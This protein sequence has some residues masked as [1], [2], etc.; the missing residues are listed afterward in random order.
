[1]SVKVTKVACQS[2]GANLSLDESIRFVTCG[3]C[4]AQLEIVHDRSTIHSKILNEVIKR[5]DAVEQELRILRLEKKIQRLESEWENF[6]QRVCS[7]DRQGNLVEPNRYSPA[8]MGVCAWTLGLIIIVASGPNEQWLGLIIG[9][10]ILIVSYFVT[11]HGIRRAKE[12]A[13]MRSRYLHKR[14]QLK[15]ELSSVE[16]RLRFSP[17]KRSGKPGRRGRPHP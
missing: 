11:R 7:K 1:M 17:M 10:A 12:F 5:Q 9:L 15:N 6:R 14:T 13:A 16:R 2:C 3:Y 8:I 4:S